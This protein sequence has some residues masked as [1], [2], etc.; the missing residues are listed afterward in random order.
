MTLVDLTLPTMAENLAFDEALLDICEEGYHGEGILRFWEAREY[1]VVLG[2]S[3]AAAREANLPA[4]RLDNVPVFRRRSGGGAVLQGPGCL[5]YCLILKS[6]GN[7]ST[8][9]GT[10]A[11][12]LQRNR[13]AVEEVSGRSVVQRGFTDLAVNDIKFSGN[14]QRRRLCCLMFHGTFLLDLDLMRVERYLN[15]PSKQPD[16]RRRRSH[17]AFLMNLHVPAARLKAALA[18]EWHATVAT[19][20][21]PPERMETLIMRWYENR[22]WTYRM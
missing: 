15:I 13:R 9:N 8:I 21:V 4:C 2:S 5:S 12:V 17:T 14:S 19:V 16:Y 7:L 10:N 20:P 22:E 18:N 11:F 1:A 3:N 6:E